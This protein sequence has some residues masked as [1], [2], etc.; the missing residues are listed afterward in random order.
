[1][2]RRKKTQHMQEGFSLPVQVTIT[3]RNLASWSKSFRQGGWRL[4]KKGLK[5]LTPDGNS[6]HET[7]THA[8]NCLA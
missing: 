2:S 6:G 4:E 7:L 8:A 3:E 5:T 1:M